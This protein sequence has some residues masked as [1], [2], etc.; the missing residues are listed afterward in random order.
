MPSKQPH[1][2]NEEPNSSELAQ[3]PKRKRRRIAPSDEENEESKA[4]AE[5]TQVVIDVVEGTDSS[6]EQSD[7][8]LAGPEDPAKQART[9]LLNQLMK[10]FRLVSSGLIACPSGYLSDCYLT[11]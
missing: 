2:E 6:A 8:Q 9:A 7:S 4:D 3:Q 5:S 10:P 1:L 11:F